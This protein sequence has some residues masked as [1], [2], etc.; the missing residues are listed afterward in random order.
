[1]K[2]KLL[3]LTTFIIMLQTTIAQT[4]AIPDP[5]FEQALIDLGID[6]NGLNGNILQ[7]Q[8]VA[9]NGLNVNGKNISSLQGIEGF[10][11]ITSLQFWG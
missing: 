6:T 7:S 8:A 4:I 3:F 10:V 9:V 5:N 1:M 11:N 2:T